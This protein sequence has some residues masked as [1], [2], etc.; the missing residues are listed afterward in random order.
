M[1][2]VLLY[3]IKLWIKGFPIGLISSGTDIIS[4]YLLNKYSNYDL[5]IQLYISSILALF[6]SFIGSKYWTFKN[7]NSSENNLLIQIILYLIFELVFI[8]LLAEIVIKI[9]EYINKLLNNKKEFF[10]HNNILLRI[11][12][13]ETDKNNENIKITNNYEIILKHVLIMILYTFIS[14]PI[15]DK[16]I[17]KK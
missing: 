4:L 5:N 10:V 12:F 16:Y 1:M 11:K 9:V 8:Y 13:L 15:Y 7:N 14:L 6:I 2:N 3:Y 17:F